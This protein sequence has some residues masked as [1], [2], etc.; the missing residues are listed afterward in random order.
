MIGSAPTPRDAGFTLTETLIAV[1]LL[2]LVAAA[3]VPVLRGGVNAHAQLTAQAAEREAHGAL[4]RAFRG[5][6]AAAVDAPAFVFQGNGNGL[7]FT[8]Q[9][10]GSDALLI[11][12]VRPEGRV[13]VLEAQPIAGGVLRRE[14]IELGERFAGF[15]YYGAP[16]GGRPGWRTDWPGS[17][18]PRLVVL[19]LEPAPGGAI[20]RIEAAVGARAALA[21][22]YDSGLQACREGI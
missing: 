7:R 22:D 18:P 2:A 4:E 16:D 9:P 13:F 10:A 12:S 14:V 20:R 21:C 19:D 3:A 11:I 6:L 15:Q 17:N 8:A 1:A 5:A